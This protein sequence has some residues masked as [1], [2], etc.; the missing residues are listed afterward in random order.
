M[1]KM[2]I[3]QK[4]GLIIDPLIEEDSLLFL[5]ATPSSALILEGASDD[6]KSPSRSLNLT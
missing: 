3:I 2:L 5:Q 6:S 4:E 1:G